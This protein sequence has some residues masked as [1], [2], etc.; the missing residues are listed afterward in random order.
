MLC[1]S[2]LAFL[3]LAIA[4]LTNAKVNVYQLDE[5]FLKLFGGSSSLESVQVRGGGA[6]GALS[7][8]FLEQLQ[9]FRHRRYCRCA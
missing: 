5:T 8:E 3:F 1:K 4:T 9:L 2:A 6:P 7:E